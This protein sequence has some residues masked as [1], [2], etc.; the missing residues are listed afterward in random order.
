MS[1]ETWPLCSSMLLDKILYLPANLKSKASIAHLTGSVCSA[2]ETAGAPWAP[3][4][5]IRS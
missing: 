5:V 4:I 2:W 1:A 3:A